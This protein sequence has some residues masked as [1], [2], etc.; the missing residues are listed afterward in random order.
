MASTAMMRGRFS[1][2]IRRTNFCTASPAR[3]RRQHNGGLGIGEHGIEAFGVAR[4]F[5]R[6]QRN[7]DVPGLK[8]AEEA[9]HIVEALGR[10][11]R[12]AITPRRH[13]LESGGDGA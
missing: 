1:R 10:Q 7:R 9:R 3:G 6:E 11:D 13:L 8:G 2:G 4:E 12:H 5:G